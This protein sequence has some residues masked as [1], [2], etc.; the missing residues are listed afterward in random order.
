MKI[1]IPDID[2]DFANRQDALDV[3]PGGTTASI[4]RDGKLIRHNTG[5]YYTDIPTDPVTGQCTVDYKRAEEL[6]YFKL[7]LLNV[8]VYDQVRDEVHLVDLMTKTPPWSRLWEDLDFCK[9][10][11]HI[12]NHH[13]LI[14]SMKPD[15]ITRMAMFLAV[16]RPGKAHLRN[17]PWKEIAES[18]WD[19]NVDGYTFRRSHAIAYAHLVVVHMNLSDFSN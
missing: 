10:I 1:E 17:K 2:I 14:A 19:R 3:L 13:A 5:M 18:V 7:D 16:I 9:R 12:G 11:V 8:S 6:G 4:E 15:S